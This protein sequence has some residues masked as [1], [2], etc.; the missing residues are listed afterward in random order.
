MRNKIN[1][2]NK[3]NKNGCV[4]DCSDEKT[5][6]KK[7]AAGATDTADETDATEIFDPFDSLN[8]FE[9]FDSKIE[10]YGK[11]ANKTKAEY[12]AM[13]DEEKLE[14]ILLQYK[15]I[16]LKVAKKYNYDGA[17]FQDMYIQ[18]CVEILEVIEE[19]GLGDKDL[20]YHILSRVGVNVKRK[21]DKDRQEYENIPFDDEKSA[22]GIELSLADFDRELKEAELFDELAGCLSGQELE[23]AKHLS[24]YGS[25]SYDEIAEIFG[26]SKRTAARR[27]AEIR[28]KVA[29]LRRVLKS[30]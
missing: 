21:G 13:S 28:K 17:E 10:F 23:I 1:K 14:Y 19:F 8:C 27:L 29:P 16:C 12:D 5:R 18:A 11:K 3:T 20:S 7:Y 6:N 30:A 26:I 25:C 24:K 9:E 2:L 15:P 22:Q 4:Y